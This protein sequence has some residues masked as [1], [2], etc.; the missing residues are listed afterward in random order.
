MNVGKE[1]LR[2][3]EEEVKYEA[4]NFS[5]SHGKFQGS[6]GPSEL[7]SMGIRGQAFKLHMSQALDLHH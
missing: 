2:N 6:D 5:W 1:R 4:L 7:S 3:G